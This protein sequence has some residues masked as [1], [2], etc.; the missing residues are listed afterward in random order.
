MGKQASRVEHPQPPRWRLATRV[1]FRFCFAYLGLYT[2][3]TQIFGGVFILPGLAFEAFGRVWPMREITIWC[4]EHV[5]GITSPPVYVG[6][7]GDTAFYWVQTF[8][9]LVLAG[10][11]TT[12]WSGLD[13]QRDSYVTLHKWFRLYIRFGL[14]AQMFYY[15]MAKVIPTQFRPPALVTLVEPVGNLTLTSMLWVSIGASTAYQMFTGFA[16]LAGG[17]LLLIPHTAIL[18]ALLSLA[19]MVQVLVLNM[20]YDFG[21]KQISFHLIL[22]S[23]FLLAPDL[24]RVANLLVLNRPAGASTQPAL[25]ATARANRAALITQV[26]FGLYLLGIFTNLAVGFWYEPDA[27]GSPKSPLYGIWNVEELSIDDEV[28]SAHINDYDRRWRRAIFDSPSRLIFQRTDDSFATYGASID[29][30]SRK[31]ALTKGNSRTWA[32]AFTFERPA[33]DRLILDGEM[34]GYRIRMRLELVGLDTFQLLNSPFR[35]I[36]PPDPF[37]SPR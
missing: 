26:V 24:K 33:E 17:L 19:A 21:L 14:A 28:R 3:A 30:N 29:M 31:I 18:G 27:P 22:L 10:V 12:A 32:S 7:S 35:W 34:D 37:G 25:F 1:T 23:L 36:R 15:G 2:F 16:E 8:W 20:A 4:M 9:L 11:V 6:N 13:R 5:F